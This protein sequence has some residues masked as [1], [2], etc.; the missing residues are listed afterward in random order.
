MSLNVS[1]LMKPVGHW[2]LKLLYI[3]L[4]S[5]SEN[6]DALLSADNDSG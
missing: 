2:D 3:R 6:L 5:S 1:S 4:I